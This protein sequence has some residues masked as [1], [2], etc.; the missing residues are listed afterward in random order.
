MKLYVLLALRNLGRRPGRTGLTVAA[1]ACGTGLLIMALG[2]LNGMIWDLVAGATES[3]YGHAKVTAPRYLERRAIQFTLPEAE[4]PGRVFADPEVLARS[5]RV[6]G[7]FLLSAGEGE[8]SRSQPAEL[9]GV[10]PR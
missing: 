4:P 2:L 6:R 9:L 5:A 7:F 3:Y 1:M 8:G 10:D